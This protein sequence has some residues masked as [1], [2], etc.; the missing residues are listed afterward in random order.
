MTYIKKILKHII[1]MLYFFFSS[2]SLPL[3]LTI[4]FN[5]TKGIA[6]NP[7]GELLIPF[8]IIGVLIIIIIDILIIRSHLINV[9]NTKNERII[10]LS[11]SFVSI[12]IGVLL[13]VEVWNNFFKC[14]V[15]YLNT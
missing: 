8:G 10:V 12:I 13:P 4:A 3:F 2:Y 5:Y 11:L 15:F 9:D 6:N 1:R 7:D 14:F